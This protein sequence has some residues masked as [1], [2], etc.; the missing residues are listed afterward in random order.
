[1]EAP[2][3]DTVVWVE[4]MVGKRIAVSDLILRREQT[5]VRWRVMMTEE[6]VVRQD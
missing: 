2:K 1:M 6:R 4:S 3:A 5:E